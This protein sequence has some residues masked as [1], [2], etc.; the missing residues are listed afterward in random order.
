MNRKRAEPTDPLG[1]EQ[2]NNMLESFIHDGIQILHP[3]ILPN[4]K[5][6]SYIYFCIFLSET[7]AFGI[8]GKTYSMKWKWL[9]C[10]TGWSA[11][12]EREWRLLVIPVQQLVQTNSSAPNKLG[13]DPV[14]FQKA[15]EE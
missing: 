4:T 12:C 9:Q 15:A 14:C 2:N 6:K 5:C 10:L 8:M 7:W 3:A 13:S 1:S 11:E